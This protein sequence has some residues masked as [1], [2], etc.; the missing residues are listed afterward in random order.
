MS[1]LSTRL[2][3]VWSTKRRGPWIQKEWR[4]RLHGYMRGTLEN[5]QAKVF[6]IGGVEDHVHVYCSLPATITIANLVSQV[7]A[8]SSGWVH[9]FLQQP[10]G[11]Q[12]GYA[13]FTMSKSADDDV[14]G[15]IL[16]Q[17]EHHQ[18]VSYQEELIKMF[19]KF[20]IPYDPRYVVP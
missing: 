11:W 20:Q 10:F 12:D 1:Y 7:K 4:P 8:S 19:E 6:V 17:E 13:A 15:Y 3:I 18:R 9:E 14:L 16:R 2:H 5:L